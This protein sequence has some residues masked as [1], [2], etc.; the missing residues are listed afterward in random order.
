MTATSITVSVRTKLKLEVASIHL[1][2]LFNQLKFL[3]LC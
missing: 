2:L 3:E 1:L